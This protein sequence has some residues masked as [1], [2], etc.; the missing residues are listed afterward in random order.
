MKKD[1]TARTVGIALLIL[2]VWWALGWLI[3][4]ILG[5]GIAYII[6]RKQKAKHKGGK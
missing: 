3:A 2:V 1:T 6:E 5:L 4:L